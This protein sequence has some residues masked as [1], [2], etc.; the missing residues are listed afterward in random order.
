MLSLLWLLGQQS[1]GVRG[2]VATARL[3]LVGLA[4]R[5]FRWFGLRHRRSIRLAGKTPVAS[6]MVPHRPIGSPS[7][8]SQVR[9]AEGEEND[10]QAREP[11]RAGRRLRI[12]SSSGP[13]TIWTT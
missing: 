9:V 4:I 12:T 5:F 8:Y 13:K 11:G 2:R 10:R 6:L 3:M 7:T 1:I